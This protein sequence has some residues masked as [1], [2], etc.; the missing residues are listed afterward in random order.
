MEYYTKQ[1]FDKLFI[2]HQ[3]DP[4]SINR[5]ELASTNLRK[6]LDEN[7]SRI[8]LDP[9]E[10]VDYCGISLSEH[11]S[12]KINRLTKELVNKYGFIPNKSE[13][14]GIIYYYFKHV[15]KSRTTLK[16]I[17]EQCGVSTTSISKISNKILQI[18]N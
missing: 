6:I 17:Q 14:A 16:M 2:L 3:I 5:L 1:K 8:I 11:D 9:N 12:N 4:R 7:Y 13:Q 10:T 18:M 15:V